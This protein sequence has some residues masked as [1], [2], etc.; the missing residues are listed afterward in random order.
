MKYVANIDPKALVMLINN[1]IGLLDYDLTKTWIV[2]NKRMLKV[3]STMVDDKP[4]IEKII[5]DGRK[6]NEEVYLIF[7]QPRAKVWL[8]KQ[9]V[10]LKNYL[11][12]TSL[13]FR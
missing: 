6:Y 3:F 4:D 8:M 9:F 12:G 1:N 7:I 2:E 10:S 13:I 11:E 5:E